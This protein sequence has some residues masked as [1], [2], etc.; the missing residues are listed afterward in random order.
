MNGSI[1]QFGLFSSVCLSVGL[2]L[3]S[4]DDIQARSGEQVSAYLSHENKINEATVAV[5]LSQGY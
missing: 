1:S 2:T 3:K 5:S 4:V